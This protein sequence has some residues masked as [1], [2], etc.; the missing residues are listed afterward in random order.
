MNG[1]QYDGGSSLVVYGNL[2]GNDSLHLY[3][4]DLEVKDTTKVDVTFKKTSSDNA[5][6]KLGLIFK[7]N[8]AQTV[9][10]DIANSQ[11]KGEWTTSQIDLS[12][13]AGRKIAAITLEF[14]GTAANYQMNVGGL[15]VSD[16][17]YKPATPTGF[18]VDYAY[19]DGQMIVSWDLPENNYG[20]VVQYNLYGTL[21][22]GRRVYLGGTYD[23]ILYVKSMF[24]E[25][26][27][28]ELELC[29]VGKDGTESE[30][31]KATYSYE[32]KVSNIT[33]KEAET[34]SG[35]LVRAANPGKLEVSFNAPATVAPDSYEFEVTLRNI[36][37]DDPDNQVYT[38]TA[39]GSV[40]SAEV[41][42]PVKEGYEYDLKIYAVE[43]GQKGEAICYRGW[44]NDSYSEPIAEEDIRISGT[45][46]RLVDPD[47]VDWYEMTA[48]FNG[49]QKASFKRGAVARFT[50]TMTFSIP[51]NATGILSVV[52]EDFAGNMSEPTILQLENG[53]PV[54]PTD[55]ISE[56][57]FPD[58]A[59]LSAVK[60][61]VGVTLSSLS[62][63]TGTLDLSNTE[64]ANLTGIERLTG[65][66]GLNLENC[67][68]L[69]ELSGLE[70]CKALK[71]INV[72]GCTGLITVDVAGLGLEKFEGAGEY[73]NLTFVDIS[74]NKL[75]LSTGT[76]ERAFLDAALEATSGMTG[77]AT[78]EENLVLG[79]TLVASDNVADAAKFFDGDI[80][81]DTS[82][83]ETATN[84]RDQPA[85]I[86]LNLGA[87]KEITAFSIWAQMNTDTPPRPFGVK[88]ATL[89]VC[90][91]ADG[92]YTKVGVLDVIPGTAKD[93]I[94]E[95]RVE[96][97]KAVSAQYVKITVTEWQPHPNGYPDWPAMRETAVY[98]GTSAGEP[99][100]FAD[101]RPVAYAAIRSI[102]E[103]IEK[104][105]ADGETLDMTTYAKKAETIRGTAYE[106][107]D[108]QLINGVKFIADDV[109]VS[110]KPQETFT[111]SIVDQNRKP[112]E[113]GVIN[114]SFDAT[115]TVT[116]KTEGGETAATL[117]VVVGD[118]G[119]VTTPDVITENPTILYATEQSDHNSAED[120]KF[121]FDNDE[122]TK[123]CPGGNAVKA[124]M[125][126]DVGEYYTLTEWNMSHAGVNNS[127]GPGRNTRDFALQVLNVANPTAEQLADEDF[128]KNDANWT[129]VKAYENNQ[130]SRTHYEFT[131][132]VIGRYFRLNVTKG[133]TSAQWPSTR[134][135]EW[136]MKG[137]P[138]DAPEAPEV[139]KAGLQA[140]YDANKD[141]VEDDYTPETWTAFKAALDNAAAVLTDENAA[142]ADVD[143]AKTALEAAVAALAEKADKE[144]LQ[145]VYEENK[146]RVEDEYTPETWTAFKAALDNAAAVLA[147]ENAAQA[148]VDTAKTAL[149]A[150]VAALAEK[151]DKTKLEALIAYAEEA[152][153][154]PEYAT[155]VPDVQKA[156]ESALSH[157]Q[158]IAADENATKAEV[159]AAYDE[160]LKKTWMLSFV[161][162]PEKLQELYDFAE[163][164]DLEIYTSQT[165]EAVRSAMEAAELILNDK[166]ALQD[167]IDAAYNGLKAAVDGLKLK[168][169]R[170]ALGALI[171]E[172][173]AIDLTKYLESSKTDFAAAL[174][175]AKEVFG[176]DQSTDKAIYDAYNRL[177][178]AIFDLRLIPD[179]SLLEDLLNKATEV[180]ESKYT[181]ESY[182]VLKAAMA[183]AK[184]VFANA[185]ATEA[186]VKAAEEKLENA[187]GG[188]V[189]TDAG[190]TPEEPT[191]PE[192]KPE[193]KPNNPNTDDTIPYA[194]PVVL[195]LAAG[196]VFI[197]RKRAMR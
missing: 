128:L 172:A 59:L 14:E 22:D 56:K 46:V 126:I 163:V 105:V 173:E 115:Y 73:P 159:T 127:D 54:D 178:R 194:V 89:S 82:A 114:L 152:K 176:D 23:S 64:V 69:E 4:T 95:T 41:P 129:T 74:N 65:M 188:L 94:K 13:Y 34:A 134:I 35:L 28:V 144:A 165:A 68:S 24:G 177:Q 156:F 139:D 90:D 168:V 76:P 98:G 61:Q 9:K 162:S 53:V 146:D 121:A 83:A 109:D 66:T 5:Q 104:A 116:Y 160:L 103:P 138:A 120:P 140:V 171:E 38:Y 131:E 11:K 87:V 81:T 153:E 99:V 30:P 182:G 26:K 75:D 180:D 181:A 195:V 192:E 84:K 101:Q 190:E 52:T 118:G 113:G 62:E 164:L 145:A 21:S 125:V 17:T 197:I 7:D 51:S 157:A 174:E 67:T 77:A 158:E 40:T 32:D 50:A 154:K 184:A 132:S 79:A 93:E 36:A 25:T 187:L 179:K 149:E 150:A 148:D 86:T 1:K 110:A 6:M 45:S 155:V 58:A 10:L 186:D 48:T 20:N 189:L 185:E 29:A 31:A 88:K 107:L 141:R 161:G 135:Y 133:D 111:V 183:D 151:A 12:E 166:N 44:S 42:L 19:A 16:S 2:T 80:N 47:S 27:V 37:S 33:V 71:E 70:A 72:K 123:W 169:D 196:S 142:Q 193:D 167:E 96:L 106:T 78:G 136:S 43:D 15:K 39:D 147:D 122:T 117:T 170:D 97:S 8:A 91:T 143:T 130:E 57:E 3:K 18:T 60:A 119:E 191:N 124:Q 63:F 175:N 108:T 92:T 55:L 100:K 85:S 112:V 102:T 49:Q 137:I